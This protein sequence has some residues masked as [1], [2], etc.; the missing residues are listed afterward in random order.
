MLIKQIIN[1]RKVKTDNLKF[2][3]FLLDQ[4]MD[5]WSVAQ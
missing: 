4:N 1:L 2:R 5:G 3:T